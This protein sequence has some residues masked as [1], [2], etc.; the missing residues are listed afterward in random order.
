MEYVT[1]RIWAAALS[2]LLLLVSAGAWALGLGN[3][4][5][6]STLNE[7]LRARISLSALQVGD[8]DGMQV[9][10]ASAE[11]FKRAGIQR[12]FQLSKL[13]FKAVEG[14]SDGGH[15][16]V[17]TRD[18]VVE[19]F[20][21]FLVEVA[22]PRG[23]IVREYTILLD[24]PVYGAAISSREKKNL[25]EIQ[26]RALQ[27]Q[28]A[29]AP[30]PAP[31]PKRAEP[32]PAA[33]MA[34]AP[35]P[36]VQPSTS[37]QVAPAPAP[38]PTPAPSVAAAP[39]PQPEPAP[40]PQP[41]PEPAAQPA[42]APAPM[43]M[44]AG[45]PAVPYDVQYGDTLWSLATRYR[46]DNSVSI[47][48]MMLAMLSANPD[49]F[50]I[51]NINA[52]RAGTVLHVPDVSQF[53]AADRQVVLTEV[54]RQHEVW[55][56]YRQ[57][58]AGAA[59]QAPEGTAVA[60]EPA[61][62]TEPVAE[63]TQAPAPSEPTPAAG[64]EP[65]VDDGKL[66]LVSGGQGTEGAGSASSDDPAQARQDLLQAREEADARTREAEELNSRVAELEGIVDDLKRAIQLRDDNIAAL[67]EMLAKVEQEAGE[68]RVAAEQAE[69]A[70]AAAGG[71]APEPVVEV[72]PEPVV[73]TAPE[74]V[75][76]TAPEPVV[77]AAP[78]PVVEAAPEP[79]VEPAPEPVVEAA[80]EPVVESA[81]EPVV[82]AA[83]EPAPEPIVVT[84]P[85]PAPVVAPPPPPPSF[86]ETLLESLPVDPVL[87][88]AGVGGL[89]VVLG[90][91]AL[92]RRRR[93]GEDVEDMGELDL[94]TLDESDLLYDED[95][96][97]YL[98][99]DG[100]DETAISELEGMD[101]SHEQA[102]PQVQAE[103]SEE[104][105]LESTH[106]APPG[107]AD[108]AAAGGGDSDE[109]DPLT[110][111]NVYLAYERYDQ[112]EE[113][114]RSAIAQYPDR[115]EYKLRLL[116]VFYAAKDLGNFESSARELQDAVG[117]DS[118]LV[119]EAHKMWQDMSPGRDLFSEAESTVPEDQDVVFD[120]TGG[121]TDAPATV[122]ASSVGG[123]DDDS[124][125]DFDLGFEADA[126]KGEAD[127]GESSLDFDLGFDQSAAG[128]AKEDSGLDLDLTSIG[129]DTEYNAAA[130]DDGGGSSVDFDLGGGDAAADGGSSSMDFDL[131][132]MDSSVGEAPPAQ[133]QGPAT[134]TPLP[135]RVSRDDD[136]LDFDLEGLGEGTLIDSQVP[137]EAPA[138][139]LP[140]PP[141]TGDA[142]DG[143]LD[144]DLDGIGGD[145]D[146]SAV[147]MDAEFTALDLDLDAAI[148]AATADAGGASGGSQLSAMDDE[149][150]SA[151]GFDIGTDSVDASAGGSVDDALDFGLD[152]DDGVAGEDVAGGAD[153]NMDLDDLGLDDMA[154]DDMAL[155]DLGGEEASE[156]TVKLDLGA[157][158]SDDGFEDDLDTVKLQSPEMD[159]ADSAISDLGMDLNLDM[160]AA[161]GG[162][163]S[164]T[165][166][167]TAFEGIF[168]E[169]DALG[170][171][172]EDDMALS[173]DG[174]DLIP[175]TPPPPS[176]EAAEEFPEIDLD[177]DA[178]KSQDAAASDE[179]EST[180]FMLRDMPSSDAGGGDAGEGHSGS[181]L[182]L[183]GGLS[184]EVDEVQTKLDLAQAYIDMGDTDGAKGII[185]EVL[186]EGNASQ[187]QAAMG[188]LSKL[189]SS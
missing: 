73:E 183:G 87:L 145:S 174:S 63:T 34:P 50:N 54:N 56:E 12:P 47:Q 179:Y 144:F 8:L 29:P 48:R 122:P 4:E 120:V 138:G 98:P 91:A 6:S 116:E 162:E 75:V 25:A 109:D 171:A 165:G 69:A 70:A 11:Q 156:E 79:V 7:P 163:E 100:G 143:A 169:D 1:T 88:G 15:I 182:M 58:L 121:D 93:S 111:V 119:A 41:A 90:G 74:P 167:D 146:A 89:L 30:V 57:G 164:S 186:A 24:P 23:R 5:V 148:D 16:T 83:P 108:S 113:L 118:T 71:T 170:G 94:G 55:Q 181:T 17:T 160:D 92:W 82:E 27:E 35:A 110:E 184:G 150:S 161:D 176:E 168:G 124:S 45:D 97:P 72:A 158:L 128:E 44:A 51:P 37:S 80:P 84:P 85:K 131:S 42:P 36:A 147:S 40:A 28:P 96:E 178:E 95:G 188:L 166:V 151:L 99:D 31:A 117:E 20:L 125:V 112:A 142:D 43:P 154:I 173:M 103:G 67:Q 21:N 105:P 114:V 106:I 137:P 126:T 107:A 102:E 68:L 14:G 62:G 172:S 155:D 139:A 76:E 187:K 189:A 61:S 9:Q 132:G 64:T 46:P 136:D 2:V 81:P 13:K 3:I 130:A 10:L 140:E 66:S 59:P 152:L 104:D 18:P 127:S 60:A 22:W 134:E 26:A 129:G 52:L 39:A 185:D 49:A 38:E 77:E 153:L 123:G 33:S 135:E 133:G 159:A 177:F 78:E 53:G 101:L 86:I 175:A 180:Q 65:A 141:E 32:E 157:A 149:A 19:P 115:N